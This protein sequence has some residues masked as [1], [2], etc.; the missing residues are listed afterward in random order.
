MKRKIAKFLRIL[1]RFAMNDKMGEGE[2]GKNKFF[3]TVFNV[4]E[5]RITFS[6]NKNDSE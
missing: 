6:K 1:L 3:C 2:R 5:R 4:L